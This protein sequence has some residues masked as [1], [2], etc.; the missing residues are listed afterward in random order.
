MAARR[1]LWWLFPSY[2]VLT[3]L[4]VIAVTLHATRVLREFYVDQIRTDLGVRAQ[5]L[6]A[7]VTGHLA[8]GETTILRELIAG[9]SESVATRLTVIDAKGDVVADSAEDPANMENHA[10]RPEFA[11]A[12]RGDHGAEVRYSHTVRQEMAYVAVPLRQDRQVIG[13]IRAAVSL[14]SIQDTLHTIYW[15]I[16]GAS[17]ITAALSALVALWLSRRISRPLELLKEGAERFARGDLRHKLAV[18]DTREIATLAQ[19][20][21][22]MAADL[23]EKISTVERERNERDAILASMVEG[24]LAVDVNER[25][26]SVNR[27]A[28]ELFGIPTSGYQGRT[29]EETVRSPQ[30]QRLVHAVL[31]EQ[32]SVEEEFTLFTDDERFLHVQGTTLRG[33]NDELIGALVVLYDVTQIKR[34]E[35]VRRDFVANVSHELKTPI[36]SI[37]GY[38]ETLLDG[39]MHEPDDAERFLRIVANQSDRLNAIIDDLLALSRVEQKAERAEIELELGAVQPVLRNAIEV[40]AAKATECGVQIDLS[41]DPQL[42]ARINAP[43][44]EQA[45]ANL[46][47][48]ACKHSPS[49]ATVWVDAQQQEQTVVIRVRDKGCGIEAHHIP[50]LFERFYRVDKSR[51]RKLGGTGL[52]LAIVKH[53]VQAHQGQ[54]W[55]ESTPNQ[56]STFS[57]CVPMNRI[58]PGTGGTE[59]ASA[60]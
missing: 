25:V 51:S 29:L 49:G 4:A 59:T 46:I 44:L 38:V 40:S 1:L 32:K 56:G 54:V 22:R 33:A 31:Q 26:L 53:I 5:L 10:S 11:A 47:H 28:A 37:K 35:N 12:L 34:L 41:C 60:P 43:L 19:S 42:Q 8:A 2:L 30:L 17:L 6:E 23:N 58:E 50:R 20:M 45:V 52:G 18:G 48:N 3:C 27:A 7:D 15:Q 39:A 9:L 21:N 24:V 16:A 57:I 14:A 36:T 55:V 13:A